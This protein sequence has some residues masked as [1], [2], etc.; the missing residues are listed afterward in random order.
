MWYLVIKYSPRLITEVVIQR[1]Y[2]VLTFFSGHFALVI[3]FDESGHRHFKHL[4]RVRWNTADFSP[5]P[6]ETNFT[7]ATIHLKTKFYLI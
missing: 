5:L 4:I 3:H 6:S 1:K 7:I 2:V